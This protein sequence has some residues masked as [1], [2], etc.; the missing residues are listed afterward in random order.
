MQLRCKVSNK[1]EAEML[2]M[3]L[4]AQL[5]TLSDET[6]KNVIETMKRQTKQ[7]GV[8][9]DVFFSE[10]ESIVKKYKKL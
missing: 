8:N 5:V 3:I 1:D 9:K 10:I 2:A 7:F 6:V 4:I